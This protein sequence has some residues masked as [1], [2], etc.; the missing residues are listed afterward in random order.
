MTRLISLCLAVWVGLFV[1]SAAEAQSDSLSQEE[2]IARARR[3]FDLGT[4]AYEAGEFP[5]AL[6]YFKRSYR[7]TKSPDLLY[8]IA[9]VADRMR[10]DE[11]ALEAYEGYIKARP[12]S[13][14][15]EHVQGR[16]RVLR[17]K[18]AERE[19]EE[20][21]TE[22]EIRRA[23][24]EAAAKVKAERPLTQ[25]VGPGPGPWITIGVSSATA[26]TGAVLLGLG[27]RDKK[28]VQNA[29]PGSNF[30]EVQDA[31]ARGPKF[32][33]AGIALLSV[34]AAGALAGLIWQLAG[35][36]EEEVTEL[37]FSPTGVSIRRSF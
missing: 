37:T 25:W 34:G 3:A 27:Q 11:D 26:V 17:K 23:A 12:K 31:Y 4:K 15:R 19:A 21:Q 5:Q 20:L 1:A 28:K 9:T 13:A 10:L 14:D 24:E 7:L 32:T 8:N 30:S 35:G 6:G 16:I 22:E 18:I 29:E 33:K 36:H 2:R